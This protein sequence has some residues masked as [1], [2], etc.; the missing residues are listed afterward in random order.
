MGG[1]GKLCVSIIII[2][3]LMS[4]VILISLTHTGNVPPGTNP[5]KARYMTKD[6]LRLNSHYG[7]PLKPPSVC[8][9]VNGNII[10]KEIFV[11]L[12]FYS[13]F[14]YQLL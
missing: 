1:S 3:W 4:R 8:V 9:L 6:L 12:T 5:F 2:L 13:Y 14:N 7:I 10:L 11:K